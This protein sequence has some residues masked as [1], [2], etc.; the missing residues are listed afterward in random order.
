MDGQGFAVGEDLGS[1]VELR[2]RTGKASACVSCWDGVVTTSGWSPDGVVR[3][4]EAKSSRP[5]LSHSLRDGL[6]ASVS[7]RVGFWSRAAIE[8]YHTLMLTLVLT[9]D[10]LAKVNVSI[11]ASPMADTEGKDDVGVCL[12]Q[13]GKCYVTCMS[14]ARYQRVLDS[15]DSSDRCFAVLPTTLILLINTASIVFFC[16][17]SPCTLPVGCSLHGRLL[18]SQ[19]WSGGRRG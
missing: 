12:S 3:A 7:M 2:C 18:K 15:S 13:D 1:D 5:G 16:V 17:H 6:Y 14:S 10:A 9:S 11:T 8:R 4:G 19:S